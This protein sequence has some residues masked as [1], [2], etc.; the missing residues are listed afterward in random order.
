M[1][2]AMCAMRESL[3]IHNRS[4]RILNTHKKCLSIRAA[5]AQ[6]EKSG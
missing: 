1:Y 2:S 6:I 5:L 4:E 3:I